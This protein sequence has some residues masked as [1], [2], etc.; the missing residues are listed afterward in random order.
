MSNFNDREK[1]QEKKFVMDAEMDFKVNARRNKI[2]GLWVAELLGKTGKDADEYA[3]EVVISDL[4]EEGD[5]DVFRK[6]KQDLI[7]VGSELSD[8]EIRS[9]MGVL[10]TEAISQI[11]AE[12]EG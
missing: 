2:L 11:K 4:E 3:I 12:A 9:R 1:A 8:V 6:V 10:M 5:D 7:A